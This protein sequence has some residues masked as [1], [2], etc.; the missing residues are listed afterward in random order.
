[1]DNLNLYNFAPQGLKS[2]ERVEPATLI[3][4]RSGTNRQDANS[5]SKQKTQVTVFAFLKTKIL[6]N[7]FR[8]SE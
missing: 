5:Y 8:Q 7:Y 4:E 1:M 3:L 2:T 6:Q